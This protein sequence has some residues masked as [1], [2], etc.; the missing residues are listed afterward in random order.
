MLC[1]AIASWHIKKA[2]WYYLRMVLTKSDLQE[3]DK[4]FEKF[5]KVLTKR[6]TQQRKAINADIGEFITDNVIPPID[7]VG[8]RLDKLEDT[9]ERRFD[10]LDD[11][12]D[13]HDERFK[14]LERIHPQ[15]K[16]P[17]TV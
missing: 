15:G 16:H 13:R 12:L 3:I 4:R 5:D 10:K 8:E 1:G 17:A 11:R 2:T 14:K 6:L 9:M 7:E